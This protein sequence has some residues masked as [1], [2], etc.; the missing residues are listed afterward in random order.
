MIAISHK[1][2]HESRV[3]KTFRNAR[4]NLLFY[5]LSLVLSFFSRKI[6][7]DC[8]GADFIGLTTTLGT[9]LGF[10]NLA[11][12]G[13]SSAIAV[14]L[15]APLY[16][17]DRSQINEIVSV[18][19]YLYSIVGK[20][21]LGAGI[22][23]SLFFPLIF[24]DSPISQPIIYLVFFSFL[25]SA[26][27]G[28]FINYKQVLLSADQRNYVVAAYS[29]TA[30]LIKTIIQMALA[31]YTGNYILWAVIEFSYGIVFAIILRWKVNAVYP[32]LK[33][34]VKEGKALIKKYPRI[35]QN[36][37]YLF[38]HKLGGV[39]YSQATPF[40][41]YAFAS[42]QT[43]AYYGNYTLITTKLAHLFSNFLGGSYSSVGNLI[44]EG[45]KPRILKVYWELMSIRFIFAGVCVFAIYNLLPA[46]IT[47]W[48]G[49][50]YIMSKTVLIL[51]LVTFAQSILRGVT[52]EFLNG[53]GLFQDIWA[54]FVEAV[55]LFAVA[56]TCG[57]LWGFEGTLLG[58]ISSSFIIIYIW[59]PYF[60]FKRGLRI[61][62]WK[63]WLG[64]SKYLLTTALGFFLSMEIINSI[65]LNIDIYTNWWSWIVYATIIVTIFASVSLILLLLTT[66]GTRDL[67]ARFFKR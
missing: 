2:P 22:I 39:A 32:W 33:S 29:Q 44:A 38:I 23:L 7:L 58:T 37:K 67:F 30:N 45:D 5:F 9:L 14:V 55:L 56:I 18:L 16:D 59:K 34:D 4:V 10:L 41:V 63:Y 64:F 57:S 8:L 24:S 60:L 13:V 19:G 25:G 51:L 48:L 52:D 11:E 1:S 21:I 66:R 40:L 54:P 20:I 50:E 61:S 17:R 28:Y 36:I 35:G 65:H 46:F 62:I 43:V 3:K 6:F 49:K 42:L 27:I 12:S 26:L 53:Y 15:Y 47:L 31:Y